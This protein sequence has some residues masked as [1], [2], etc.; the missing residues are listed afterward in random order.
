MINGKKENR[1]GTGRGVIFS[2]LA[3]DVDVYLNCIMLICIYIFVKMSSMDL[4]NTT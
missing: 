3:A 2:T 1:E 4:N